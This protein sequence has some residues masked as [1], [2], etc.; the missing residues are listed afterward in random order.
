[1]ILK[2]PGKKTFNNM[3]RDFLEKRKKDLNAYLQVTVL[4]LRVDICNAFVVSH[5]FIECI[6]LTVGVCLSVAAEPRDGEGLPNADSLC[7]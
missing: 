7:V 3:D 6:L 2:L 5:H 4:H 1:M